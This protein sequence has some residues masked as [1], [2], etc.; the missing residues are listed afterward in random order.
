M[1]NNFNKKP[2]FPLTYGDQS[3]DEPRLSDDVVELLKN[4]KFQS[5]MMSVLAAFVT[6]ISYAP[7]V[8][9]IPAEYGEAVNEALN[10]AGQ[11]G[12]AGGVP[13]GPPIGKITGQVPVGNQNGCLSAMPTEQQRLLAGQ[14]TGQAVPGILGQGGQ[15][16]TNPPSFFIP[17]KPLASG[18]RV[19]NT[20][21]FGG[22]MLIICLNA[23]WGEPVAIVM[24]S[25]GLVNLAYQVGTEIFFV[26]AK[27][28][29]RK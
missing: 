26:M 17:P 22:S 15:A 24:C 18:P 3:A 29:A 11:A 6:I 1:I 27:T 4:K 14:Q 20:V 8:Q 21:A 28:M 9:A 2:H 5:H 13:A 12:A 7:D 10:Q 19:I 16:P 23:M 25:A